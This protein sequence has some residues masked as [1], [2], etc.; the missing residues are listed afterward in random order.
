[1]I[2]GA[3]VLT[4][5]NASNAVAEDIYKA[6]LK[7]GISKPEAE[8]IVEKMT[9]IL[10]DY[11]DRQ[12]A[13]ANIKYYINRRITKLEITIIIPGE[14]FDPFSDGE[15]ARKLSYEEL[16]ILNTR[17]ADVACQYKWKCNIISIK[18]PLEEKHRSIFTNPI[19]WAVNLGIVC[20]FIL[21]L[22]PGE[23]GDLMI[24]K[25]VA[26]TQNVI[27][28]MISGVMG[29]MILISMISS[30]SALGSVN[31]LTNLGFKI[32]GRFLV[33]SL[34]LTALAIAVSGLIFRNFGRSILN[35][36]PDQLYILFLNMIP[37]NLISPILNTNT[38]QLVIMGLLMG[39]GI[40]LLG[41]SVSG[42][43]E[44][45]GQIQKWVMSIMRVIMVTLPAIPFFCITTALAK[46]KEK[47]L[48]SGWR[49]IAASYLI[50]AVCVLLKMLKTSIRTGTRI[51][52]LWQ[53]VKSVAV[54]SF[55][56][57]SSTAAIKN[58]YEVS[59]EKLRIRQSFSSLWIPM[60][61][62]MLSP[63]TTIYVI[64]GAFMGARL[65]N[66]PISISFLAVLLLITMELSVASPGAPAACM[67]MLKTIGL[68]AE[69]AGLLTI[70][71]LFTD[72]FGTACSCSYSIL[73]EYELAFKLKEVTSGGAER[74]E[75]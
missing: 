13:G 67:V 62:A 22:L 35:F 30:I 8:F 58:M 37:T 23:I 2:R 61:S 17:T 19:F 26:P 57:G 38:P 34:F 12:G 16:F 45:I 70:Y 53:K 59:D 74:P 18:V 49:F 40:L 68:P 1:M 63:Q 14:P 32:I 71:R 52:D 43:K 47:E 42:L 64:V 51:P 3:G 10:D 41:D 50:Y 6:I 31:E 20:G 66:I 60:M 29:P 21:R 25:I 56:T 48:L 33:I 69:Y 36:S 55:K 9:V 24:D 65:G 15:G 28:G 44:G 4:E 7:T 54:I 46:G 75:N 5:R 72:N 11:A 27:F 73:E 39:V